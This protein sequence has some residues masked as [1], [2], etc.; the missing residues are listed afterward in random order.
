MLGKDVENSLKSG[1]LTQ[2]CILFH[3]FW[4][5]SHARFEKPSQNRNGKIIFLLSIVFCCPPYLY[6]VSYVFF[7]FLFSFS[8]S[9]SPL[10]LSLSLF[11]FPFLP[12]IFKSFQIR[13]EIIPPPPPPPG[14]GG[15]T[16]LY[17]T[18]N[19]KIW[20]ICLYN[21][22]NNFKDHVVWLGFL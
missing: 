5:P 10:F 22:Y 3:I 9:F 7:F 17:W 16:E 14:R 6:F 21:S 13:F 19:I 11:F 12:P 2:G 1:W 4:M 18:L 8:P 15:N 20:F